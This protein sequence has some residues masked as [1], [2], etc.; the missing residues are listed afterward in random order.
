MLS[1]HPMGHAVKRGAAHQWFFGLG[2]R[3]RDA[4]YPAL[5]SLT[6]FCAIASRQ[7]R[8][9]CCQET[10]RWLPRPIL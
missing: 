2:P 9:L 5:S 6:S 8:V 7:R 4:P 3:T 1:H 10:A